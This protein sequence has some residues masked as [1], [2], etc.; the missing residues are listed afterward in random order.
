M[1]MAR[2]L[3]WKIQMIIINYNLFACLFFSYFFYILFFYLF[4]FLQKQAM[5]TLNATSLKQNV[6]LDLWR[7]LNSTEKD[8]RNVKDQVCN[9]TGPSGRGSG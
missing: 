3:T 5:A 9:L 4:F 8:L 1:L 6:F 2:Y 7:N